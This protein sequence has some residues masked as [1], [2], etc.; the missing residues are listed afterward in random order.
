MSEK[1][2]DKSKKSCVLTATGRD[3]L[4]SAL[5]DLEKKPKKCDPDDRD[6]YYRQ[7]NGNYIISAIA[8]EVGIDRNVVSKILCPTGLKPAGQ[9]E[10][11]T[12]SSLDKL[13]S[14]LRRDLGDDDFNVADT[15]AKSSRRKQ[16]PTAPN[17]YEEFTGALGELNYFKQ[18]QSF[19]NTI[20][21]VRPAATFLIHGK[22]DFGQRWLVNQMRYKVPY[23]SE[24]WQKSI[25]IKA[26]RRNIENIWQSL[27]GE[28]GTST[29]PQDIV[30]GLYQHWQ[31]STVILAIHDVSYIAGQN[32]TIFMQQF[33]QPLVSR[34]NNTQPSQSPQRPYRLLLFLIDY[35]NSKSKLE[36]ASLGLLRNADSNQPYIPLELPELEPFNEVMINDW[37]GVNHQVLSGLWKSSENIESVMQNIIEGDHTPMFVLKQICEC[38]ELEWDTDIASKLAL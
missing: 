23:H 8:Q 17:K 7:S 5:E 2:K 33:W 1:S 28:L 36:K 10:P 30:E 15:Q 20:T 16:P 3:K 32:L 22:P 18:K 19:Q 25:H 38:F 35:T 26:H 34:V 37:V 9:C 24:A 13:F 14:F 6:N 11:L 27:A 31:K 12:F 4:Q 29:E 21:Q